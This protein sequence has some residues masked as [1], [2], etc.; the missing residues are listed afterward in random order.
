MDNGEGKEKNKGNGVFI[1]GRDAKHNRK[2]IL[3]PTWIRI[4]A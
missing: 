3:L 2:R 1:G 4:L